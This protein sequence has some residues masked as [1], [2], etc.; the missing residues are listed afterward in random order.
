MVA[1]ATL[2]LLALGAAPAAADSALTFKS[3]R[4]LAQKL[5]DK[6]EQKRSLK[7]ARLGHA[8]RVSSNRIDFAYA[9]RSSDD[10]LC[11]ATIVV[12]QSGDH[13]TA[14]LRDVECDGIP[15][16]ILAY[17]RITR[18]MRHRARGQAKAVRQSVDDLERSLGKCDKVV[19][20]RNRRDEVEVIV[21][22]GRT[23]AF[24]APL[25][26]T[27]DKF[28]IAL[29]DVHGEDPRATR[30][31]DAWDRTLVLIGQ[32]P[33]ATKRPC[34]AIAKWAENDFSDDSAPADF[35]QLKVIRQQFGAQEKI[36]NEASDYLGEAGVF[37]AIARAFAPRGLRALILPL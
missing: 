7:F 12:E 36:L 8:D 23:R 4:H 35:T 21:D 33:P 34:K 11:N 28:N 14:E 30:G 16:E 26:A 9:D 10:V 3:A 17:E 13:R 18:K 25:R 27:L 37:P 31:I 2:A 20:P 24:Y 5:A 15:G 19:V 1:A 32:L 22:L 29:H 6:Q